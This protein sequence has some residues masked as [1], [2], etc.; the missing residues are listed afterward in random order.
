MPISA[1]FELRIVPL[2]GF[3]GFS[4]G[5]GAVRIARD[6]ALGHLLAVLLAAAAFEALNDPSPRP[7]GS[8]PAVNGGALGS[9]AVCGAGVQDKLLGRQSRLFSAHLDAAEGLVVI[10][11]GWTVA[12]RTHDRLG[13]S[14]LWHA[15][16]RAIYWADFY[17]PVLH[18]LRLGCQA[19]ESWTLHGSSTVG[20][21][22]FASDGR[23]ILALDRG[24]TLFDPITARSALIADPNGGREG[25]AYN[26]GKVDR[27][28]RL[29]I[30]TFDM[31]ETDPRGILYCLRRDGR[32]TVA[33]SGFFVCNGPAFSPDGGTL[34]FSD[35]VGRR[36]LA[37]EVTGA[38]PRLL[39][40]RLFAAVAA[41]EG[42]PDG[43][44]V[45]AA[46]DV[47]CA[48]YGAG[49]IA[50]Y[51]AGGA[52]KARYR[53]PCPAVTSCSF[54]GERLST[55]FVTT[56]WS[57][58]VQRAEDEPASGGALFAIEVDA[59]G[60]PEPEFDPAAGL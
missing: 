24:L 31:A 48:L 50:R 29:W 43:L 26:D 35:T 39:N 40:R 33:D 32:V 51:G 20:S 59:Q 23:L 14:A 27:S 7:V 1:E 42:A 34:Y 45:D 25:V 9:V 6:A 60:L 16:E 37:Y 10:A 56:G 13:E 30:G 12:A 58:G 21:F 11:R 8:R 2:E 19:V 47:W 55:L 54:G 36:I 46:G 15:R 3:A 5:V 49:R 52:L 44:T 4:H 28:G 41:D 38:P 53:L 17:G 57:P 22:A 18:R